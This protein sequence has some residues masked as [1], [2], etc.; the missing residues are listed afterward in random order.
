MKNGQL[1][2][3]VSGLLLNSTP[4]NSKVS[5]LLNPASAMAAVRK[6]NSLCYGSPVGSV[7]IAWR[8]ANT[9][10]PP[11]SSNSSSMPVPKSEADVPEVI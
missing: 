1:S 6:V 2:L 11:P 8:T 10:L 9:P 3:F 4:L 7:S 5:G